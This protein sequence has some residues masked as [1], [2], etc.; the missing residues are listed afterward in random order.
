M[1]Q[2]ASGK[3]G[4]AGSSETVTVSSQ[5][6]LARTDA[7]ASRLKALI[8]FA[9]VWDLV[10][11]VFGM[12][13][14]PPFQGA[15]SSLGLP[16]TL[17]RLFYPYESMFFH[18]LAIPFVAALTYVVLVIFRIEGRARTFIVAASTLG[19]VIASTSA[20]Y[21]VFN[22]DVPAAFYALWT[23]LGLSFAA[24]LGLMVALRP[25]RDESKGMK[26]KGRKLVELDVWLSVICL[27]A[28]TTVGAYASSGSSQWGAEASFRG[29]GLVVASHTHVVIT[30][31][32]VAL[33]AMI[34]RHF[35]GDTYE[36]IPG[37]FVKLGLYGILVGLPT[38]TVTTFATV[39]MGVAAHNA[40]T[41]FAGIL[42]QASL[43]VMYAIMAV[44][45]RRLRIRSPVGIVKNI[46]AFGL[47]FIIFWVNVVVTLPGIY[48]AINMKS[49]VGLP[50]ELAF[51]TGHEH[52]LIALTAMALVMLIA[53]VYN[54]KGRLGALAGLALTSGYIVSSGATVYY[55]FLDWN[56]VSSV[57][58]PY[59]GGGIVLMVLG[60]VCELLG[61]ATAKGVTPTKVDLA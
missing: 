11:V 37:I 58:L 2:P 56:F 36:G 5:A 6:V 21:V 47:L 42:L 17:L 14:A 60:I 19:F 43:F 20:L 41:V 1:A 10:I 49:F 25:R 13:F 23:G 4:K 54:V 31:I 28:A 40:I 52:V 30:I 3:D 53:L 16:D 33:V 61:L 18:S 55:M 15:N 22:G 29:F 34:V 26:L 46:M 50:N 9:I 32:D 57:Y 24:G 27:L 38:T 12:L 48:V 35:G 8:A 7:W 44:E 59:I 39:P 51:I 45:G